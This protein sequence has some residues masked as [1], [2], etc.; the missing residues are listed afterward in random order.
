MPAIIDGTGKNYSAQVDDKFRLV[1][2][3]TEKSLSQR[4]VEAGQAWTFG[5]TVTVT[6]ATQQGFLY[7]KNGLSVPFHVEKL[8]ISFGVSTGGT[9]AESS[10]VKVWK[11]PTTGT[12][13]SEA[14]AATIKTN[15]LFS[16]AEV[17]SS[18]VLVYTGD[19]TATVTDGT[20]LSVAN[21]QPAL[22]A[23]TIQMPV[24]FI[25]GTNNSFAVTV[26]ANVTNSSLI[27]YVVAEGFF[28][29]GL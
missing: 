11:N 2:F 7:V 12:L 15:R 19:A 3:S 17:L 29:T 22:T 14:T 16:S 9:T 18:S 6:D 10:L 8:I 21:F 27:A 13:V 4:A 23:G 24:N 1:T 25:L 20:L 26:T 28:N 5:G